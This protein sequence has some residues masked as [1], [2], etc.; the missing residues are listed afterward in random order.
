MGKNIEYK[1]QTSYDNCKREAGES[2]RAFACRLQKLLI[3]GYPGLVKGKKQETIEQFSRHKF[4]DGLSVD[5]QDRLLCLEFSS[6]RQLIEAP[7]RHDTALEQHEA[8]KKREMINAIVRELILE[9]IWQ[10]G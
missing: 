5:L 1:Y 7:E 4:L 9:L 10:C 2:V 8:R 6:F 3:K